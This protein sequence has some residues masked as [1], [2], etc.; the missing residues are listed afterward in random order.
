MKFHML[1]FMLLVLSESVMAG[2]WINMD[3]KG[4]EKI[5]RKF[6]QCYYKQVPFGSFTTSITITGN[7]FSCPRSIQYNPVTNQWRKKGF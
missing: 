5:D 2:D 3:K 1:A 4:S 7:Q 6:T